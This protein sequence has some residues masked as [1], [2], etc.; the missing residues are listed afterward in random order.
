MYRKIILLFFPLL[1]IA[2]NSLGAADC[3]IEQFQT[4]L[5][6]HYK[7]EGG[8]EKKLGRTVILIECDS[9]I[10]IDR[11]TMFILDLLDKGQTVEQI[12]KDYSE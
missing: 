10:T 2:P 6:K 11:N 4:L 3:T 1:L 5:E 12:K 7:K 9:V 8:E